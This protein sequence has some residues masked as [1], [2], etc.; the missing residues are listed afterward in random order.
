MRPEATLCTPCLGGRGGGEGI[1][2][3]TQ[4]IREG[5]RNVDGD[6]ICEK[7]E[8][9]A[10]VDKFALYMFALTDVLEASNLSS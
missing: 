10:F 5:L 7:A 3:G 1:R 6:E 9:G 2:L 4:D 8:G